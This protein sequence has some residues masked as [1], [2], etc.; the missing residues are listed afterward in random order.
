MVLELVVVSM[1]VQ[2]AGNTINECTNQAVT[3]GGSKGSD[4]SIT[5]ASEV[6]GSV[7]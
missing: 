4:T 7:L 1:G 2:M 3:R 6:V 5:L